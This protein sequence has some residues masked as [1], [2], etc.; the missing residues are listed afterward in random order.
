MKGNMG[1]LKELEMRQYKRGHDEKRRKR[2]NIKLCWTLGDMKVAQ[3][4]LQKKK[5]NDKRKELSRSWKLFVDFGWFVPFLLISLQLLN[6]L[7]SWHRGGI[8]E[9]H[10]WSRIG[11]MI[12]KL[13]SITEEVSKNYSARRQGRHWFDYLCWLLSYKVTISSDQHISPSIKQVAELCTKSR[14]RSFFLSRRSLFI[15]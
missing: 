4:K 13:F 9:T 5:K 2:Q 11:S 7:W 10:T 15:V 6:L 14:Y 1:L 8:L 3:S 12:Q